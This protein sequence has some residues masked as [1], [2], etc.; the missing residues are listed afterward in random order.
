MRN[1]HLEAAIWYFFTSSEFFEAAARESHETMEWFGTLAIS[2]QVASF[3][4]NNQIFDAFKTLARDFRRGA[5]LAKLGDYQLIW[6]TARC[7]RGDIRGMLEQPIHSWMTEAEYT[8]FDDIRI[9][10]L[11]TFARQITRALNNA[12]VKGESFF[13]PNPDCPERRDDDDG[14]PDDDIVKVYNSNV[15]WYK[16]PSFWMLPDPLPEYVIDTTVAC[17]TGDEVPWTGVWYPSTG[18][19]KHCLTFA[20]KGFRMQP[21]F[22]VTKTKEE[23]K[24]EGVLCPVAETVAVATT[25]HPVTP[26]SHHAE[27][28][29]LWAKAGEACPK[30][31]VWQP[32]DPGAAQRNYDLG[33]PMENLGSAFGLTV[34][35]WIADR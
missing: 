10:R 7:V 32:T 13:E 12:M 30:A 6:D 29:E 17:R 11:M 3:G 9:A 35:R 26:S 24:A 16:E 23:L 33:Q 31:G 21:A 2:R 25:W 28:N 22:R 4:R 20:I 8:E 1:L 19:E 34:W 14:F 15:D 27:T 18:L 5:E